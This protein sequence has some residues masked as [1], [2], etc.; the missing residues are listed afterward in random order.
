MSG[1][2]AYLWHL[3]GWSLPVLGMQ[4][5]VLVWRYRES[6]PAVLRAILPPAL[7]VT[8]WLVAGDH[9]AI[10]AGVWRFGEGKH[11]GIHLGAVPLEE[12]LFFLITNLLVVFG[13][14]LFWPRTIQG[15]RAHRD[16]AEVTP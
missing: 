14:A 11:L 5:A 12:G 1:P 13:M 9:L 7:V 6:T 2:T 8:A 4:L 16:P 15:A 10:R 3:L